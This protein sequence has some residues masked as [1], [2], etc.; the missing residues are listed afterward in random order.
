MRYSDLKSH[1]VQKHGDQLA[2]HPDLCPSDKLS[3]PVPD[4]NL[5]FTRNGNLLKHLKHDHPYHQ[6]Q[7]FLDDKSAAHDSLENEGKDTE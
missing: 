3:C 5:F 4:C 6:A 7:E 1:F 2:E